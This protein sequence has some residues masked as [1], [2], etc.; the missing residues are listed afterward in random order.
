MYSVSTCWAIHKYFYTLPSAVKDGQHKG[1]P[2][3]STGNQLSINLI[4]WKE[5]MSLMENV[6]KIFP[7]RESRV[8]SRPE[9]SRIKSSTASE[10]SGMWTSL[11]PTCTADCQHWQGGLT[12]LPTQGHAVIFWES[13]AS[14]EELLDNRCLSHRPVADHHQLRPQHTCCC[15]S[16]TG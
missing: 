3:P 15:H 7:S 2:S 13:C 8:T 6:Q 16:E 12:H 10:V 5:M 14:V 1:R 11:L 9:Q 4:L